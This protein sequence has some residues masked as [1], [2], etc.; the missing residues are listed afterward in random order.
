MA[1]PT[2]IASATR[3]MTDKWIERSPRSDPISQVVLKRTS[4][5]ESANWFKAH[6]V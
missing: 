4:E 2:A 6:E 1:M 5:I 3:M